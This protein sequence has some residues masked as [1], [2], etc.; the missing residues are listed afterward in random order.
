MLI[1]KIFKLTLYKLGLIPSS[2]GSN[3]NSNTKLHLG[4][5]TN[6]FD[7]IG[8]LL[9]KCDLYNRNSPHYGG[10]K[11]LQYLNNGIQ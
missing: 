10:I 5:A 8:N 2:L 4:V 6:F 9:G 1:Y 11:I 3:K 7:K